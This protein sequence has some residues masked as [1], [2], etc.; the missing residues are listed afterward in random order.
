MEDIFKI[1]PFNH[2]ILVTF[3]F[4]LCTQISFPGIARYRGENRWWLW[5]ENVSRMHFQTYR[6]ALKP[7]SDMNAGVCLL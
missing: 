3:S 5:D 4:L 2:M 7:V 1:I 6:N